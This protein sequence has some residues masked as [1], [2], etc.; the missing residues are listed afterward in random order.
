M[1]GR[2]AGSVGL[3]LQRSKAVLLPP[4]LLSLLGL[5]PTALQD[6]IGA[7]IASDTSLPSPV[8]AAANSATA[9]GPAAQAPAH[10]RPSKPSTLAGWQGVQA[11]DANDTAACKASAMDVSPVAVA[12]PVPLP[13]S[14]HSTPG[15]IDAAVDVPVLCE[16][17][18][19]AATPGSKAAEP[20]AA[21]TMRSS[22]NAC[23]TLTFVRMPATAGTAGLGQHPAA[24]PAPA[25]ATDQVGFSKLF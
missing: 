23:R 19:P 14:A 3:Q 16:D 12:A 6:L 5:C 2:C 10:G 17:A 9:S 4:A 21:S 20:R 7:S 11:A 25:P 13:P 24:L 1:D 8:R 18:T 22:N 15:D